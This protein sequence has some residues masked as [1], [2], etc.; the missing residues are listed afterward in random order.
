MA[1]GVAHLIEKEEG[2]ED[3]HDQEGLLGPAGRGQN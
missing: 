3:K 2:L 1:V